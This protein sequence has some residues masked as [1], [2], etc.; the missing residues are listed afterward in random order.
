MKSII[1][2]AL[3]FIL[4]Y[5]FIGAGFVYNVWLYSIKNEVKQNLR[6][7]LGKEYRVIKVP[8]S[9][10]TSPPSE[11]KWHEDH[12]FRYRGQMYDVIS[13]EEHGDQIWYFCYWDK[14]ETELLNNL[15]AYVSSFLQQQ[16]EQKKKT[17]HLIIILKNV[18]LLFENNYLPNIKLPSFS[19]LPENI[20][21]VRNF[22]DVETPPPRVHSVT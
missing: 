1:S 2:I 20:M 9:W 5:N 19:L 14:A 10:A 11:F 6:S 12:E 22:Q 21:L 13:Q 4:S 15:S 8:K 3:I 17:Q 7:E 16:P 18:F